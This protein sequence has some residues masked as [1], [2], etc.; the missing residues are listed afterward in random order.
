MSR[1]DDHPR[2]TAAASGIR[3]GGRPSRPRSRS[4]AAPVGRAHRAG[5]RV[6]RLARGGR[7]ARR[8]QPARRLDVAHALARVERRDRPR[9]GRQ[10]AADQA[11]VDAR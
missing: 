10:D 1:L 11:D 6:A 4:P 5:R 2:C 8:R 7:S 9:A 3:A